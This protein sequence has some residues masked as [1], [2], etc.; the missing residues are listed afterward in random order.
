MLDPRRAHRLI[1]YGGSFDPPHRAHIELPRQV[2]DAIGADGVL[3]VPAG[4]PPHKSRSLTDATHRLAMLRAALRD[5]DRVA[6]DT[7]EIDRHDV[8]YTVETLQH[9][10]DTLGD[11]I[12]LRLLI[13]ADMAASFYD[14]REPRRILRLAEVVVAMR[15]PWTMASLLVELPDDLTDDERR[16]WSERI[17]D[18][19]VIDVSSTALRTALRAGD[20]DAAT[21]RDH[22]DPAV[23]AYIRANNLYK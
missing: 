5:V 13:G 2:A 11:D 8:T 15:P 14:W 4:Q 19:H 17:V 16:A 22:L 9:L 1:V 20:Y 12:D 18:T 21:I 10:R 6:I 7:V 23:L 3:Y